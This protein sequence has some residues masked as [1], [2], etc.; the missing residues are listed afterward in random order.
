MALAETLPIYKDT[1][2]LL[3]IIL[4]AR[5]HFPKAY[6]YAFGEKLMMT[7][8]ECCELIQ[9]AN[10]VKDEQRVA[11]L[12]RFALKMGSLKLLLRICQD[13]R[14][15]SDGR[16]CDILRLTSSIGKQATAWRQC[17]K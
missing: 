17:S 11:Y 2:A 7:A 13:R 3:N 10:S 14:L 8:V 5:E 15:I 12:Y 4:D 1:Y 9:A 16:F 6:K